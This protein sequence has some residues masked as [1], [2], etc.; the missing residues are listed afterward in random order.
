MILQN[1]GSYLVLLVGILFANLLLMFGLMF[2]PLL[3]H[4]KGEVLDHQICKYQYVLKDTDG[5]SIR[6]ELRNILSIR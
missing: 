1:K 6:T 3:E 5:K 4:Y 2:T